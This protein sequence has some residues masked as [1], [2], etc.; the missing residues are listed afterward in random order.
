M[1]L[2]VLKHSPILITPQPYK[3]IYRQWQNFY[4]ILQTKRSIVYCQYG[5]VKLLSSQATFCWFGICLT[6]LMPLQNLCGEIAWIPIEITVFHSF[7]HF[8]TAIIPQKHQYGICSSKAPIPI[9]RTKSHCR[10]QKNNYTVFG[11][12]SRKAKTTTSPTEQH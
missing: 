7:K 5:V 3:T 1:Y 6:N 2:W 8:Q 12:S 9:K 10:T 11:W 4:T